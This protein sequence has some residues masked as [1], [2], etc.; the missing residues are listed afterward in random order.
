[1][2]TLKYI[3]YIILSLFIKN[4]NISDTLT[5]SIVKGLNKLMMHEKI[6]IEDILNYYSTVNISTIFC[7]ANYD[8]NASQYVSDFYSGKILTAKEIS[9][10]DTI[11]RNAIEKCIIEYILNGGSILLLRLC[12]IKIS[13]ETDIII[14]N[15]LST[16]VESEVYKK[17]L[18]KDPVNESLYNIMLYFIVLNIN[19]CKH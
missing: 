9:D 14:K 16:P 6:V 2:N 3:V 12:Y 1:M 11:L 10:H 5:N 4:K 13:K 15:R 19:R 17:Y 8:S 18:T 7:I